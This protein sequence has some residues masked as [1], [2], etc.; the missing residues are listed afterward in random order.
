MASVFTGRLYTRAC[1]RSQF[2]TRSTCKFPL[3]F[4]IET[5]QE[6][7]RERER[8]FDR[9]YLNRAAANRPLMNCYSKAGRKKQI[10]LP[11]GSSPLHPLD[12]FSVI[13]ATDFP[14][15]PGCIVESGS[16]TAYTSTFTMN[17]MERFLE[18]MGHSL[19]SMPL[20]CT[21]LLLLESLL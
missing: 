10:Q 6:R 2:A 21:F 8:E 15:L 14:T 1:L 19:D 11:R 7:E 18:T 17:L 16:L 13:D 5:Q 4:S 20:A 9:G 12:F 3:S